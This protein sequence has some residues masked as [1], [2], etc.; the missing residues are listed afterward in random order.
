ME[1]DPRDARAEFGAESGVLD[2]E[3]KEAIAVLEDPISHVQISVIVG[4]RRKEQSRIARQS[5]SLLGH[6]LFLPLA[7][8]P[9]T[10][11]KTRGG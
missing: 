3:A 7:A 10:R 6:H 1:A 4:V 8:R 5:R 2:G 11:A 9:D